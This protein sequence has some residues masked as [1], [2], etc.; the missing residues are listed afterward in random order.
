M[1]VWLVLGFFSFLNPAK[2]SNSIFLEC[3]RHL[4]VFLE[5][6]LLMNYPKVECV[7]KFKE[8]RLIPHLN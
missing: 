1:L 6:A 2:D 8:D 5:A 4:E 7:K 3:A